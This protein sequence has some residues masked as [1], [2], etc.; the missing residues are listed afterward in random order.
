MTTIA[1]I[2]DEASWRQSIEKTLHIAG[3]NVELYSSAEQYLDS[4]HEQGGCLVLDVELPGMDGLELQETLSQYDVQPSIIFISSSP[5]VPLSVRAMR[6]GAIDFLQK[7][8]KD[9]ELLARVQEAVDRDQH[10]QKRYAE[11]CHVND[12]IG[13]LTRREREV[14]DLVLE[15]M[16]NKEI[17]N[18]LGLS[19]R[20]VELHRSRVMAKMKA[21]SIVEL[22]KLTAVVQI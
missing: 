6:A 10:I 8:F 17:A 7:P 3:F 12:R 9:V 11:A 1:V 19:H 4:Y 2:D 21:Q 5:S 14:L 20:T 16:T 18:Q 13:S 15:G 22:V